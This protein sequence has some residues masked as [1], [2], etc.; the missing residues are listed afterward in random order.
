[1]H[2]HGFVHI[3]V[4]RIHVRNGHREDARTGTVQTRRS[5]LWTCRCLPEGLCSPYLEGRF[6]FHVK[7]LFQV[8]LCP[9][10]NRI[11]I[12]DDL[13]KEDILKMLHTQV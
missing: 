10:M 8:W 13:P 12:V 1:M 7:E 6:G 9:F 3:H 11:E 4:V 5:V 2:E